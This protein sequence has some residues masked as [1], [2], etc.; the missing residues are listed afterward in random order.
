MKII[1][2]KLQILLNVFDKLAFIYSLYVFTVLKIEDAKK[3][4]E[5]FFPQRVKY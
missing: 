5:I 2:N 3:S 1:L 4:R